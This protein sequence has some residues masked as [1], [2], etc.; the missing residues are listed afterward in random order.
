[1]QLPSSRQTSRK[2][3]LL[4]TKLG[5]QA[6]T[7]RN[8]V[9]SPALNRM[10]DVPNEEETSQQT[11][12]VSSAEDTQDNT[13]DP[14]QSNCT[15]A[16]SSASSRAPRLS[17]SQR[18]RCTGHLMGQTGRRGR[19]S[20]PT[21]GQRWKS[22]MYNGPRVTRPSTNQAVIDTTQ[23]DRFARKG[24]F[25]STSNS[26]NSSNGSG[27]RPGRQLISLN[28]NAAPYLTG[29]QP[30]STKSHLSA[31]EETIEDGTSKHPMS[32]R[33]GRLVSI[34]S[35]TTKV[36]QSLSDSNRRSYVPPKTAPSCNFHDSGFDED[37]LSAL[38]RSTNGGKRASVNL[39]SISPP[40]TNKHWRTEWDK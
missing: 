6:D 35:D 38:L 33:H 13:P 5:Q 22:A 14:S 24:S 37:S 16:S 31:Q 19:T 3:T 17:V 20:D 32:P 28:Y 40:L 25:N 30:S 8:E 27:S 23:Y 18:Q 1:M 29:N 4:E 7:A 15:E 26:L 11:G 36:S 12:G 21:N 2:K 39:P 34:N 10:L 9:R